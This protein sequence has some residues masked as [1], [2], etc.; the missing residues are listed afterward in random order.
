MKISLPP[1]GK[2]SYFFDSSFFSCPPAGFSF[3]CSRGLPF[4]K[5]LIASLALDAAL[6]IQVAFLSF[7]S[8]PLAAWIFFFSAL[9]HSVSTFY[10]AIRFNFLEPLCFLFYLL[11]ITSCSCFMDTA[12]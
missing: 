9:H 11:K 3:I 10:L 6:C 4:F 7:L 8:R 12:S 2:F 5:R 1:L